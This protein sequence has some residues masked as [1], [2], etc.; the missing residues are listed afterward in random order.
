MDNDYVYLSLPPHIVL[1]YRPL[2]PTTGGSVSLGRAASLA[3]DLTF[4]SIHGLNFLY[5]SSTSRHWQPLVKVL[6]VATATQYTSQK[7]PLQA[8]SEK[9]LVSAE[10]IDASIFS[11]V[12]VG[13]VGTTGPDGTTT[14]NLQR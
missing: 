3:L 7:C 14:R 4:Y 5:H 2:P 13:V 11:G 8:L 6:P 9:L 10:R 1:E 12:G